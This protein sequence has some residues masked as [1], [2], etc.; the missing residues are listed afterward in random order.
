MTYTLGYG[1]LDEMRRTL[2]V[3]DGEGAGEPFVASDEQAQFVIDFYRVDGEGRR[4]VRRGQ[5]T[6]PK[7]MG[8]SPLAA[9]IA[10]MEAKGPTVFDHFD[11]RV[12]GGAVG[13]VPASPWVQIAGV[14]QDAA[15]NTWA[16]LLG[17]VDPENGSP[18]TEIFPDVDVGLTRI[19]V[20]NGRLEPVTAS[21][22]T[23]RGQRVT[24]AVFD[25]SSLW[26]RSNG[27]LR[28]AE[29]IRDNLAKMGGASL[30]TTNAFVPGEDS[31]AERT[32]AARKSPGV[33][34]DWR[35]SDVEVESLRH[36]RRLRRKLEELYG[37]ASWVDLDRLVE[38]AQ[39]PDVDPHNYRR[40]FL[41][42][43]IAEADAWVSE[44][45]WS[46]IEKPDVSIPDGALVAAGFDGARFDDSTALI[47]VG[48][49]VPAVEVAGLWERPETADAWEVPYDSVDEAVD[50]LHE[51]FQVSRLYAD[52]PHWQDRIDAWAAKYPSVM[53]WETYRGRQMAAAVDRT[54]T[55]IRSGEL[56]H[57]G[58]ERLTR[59][60]LNTRY[61][62]N[63]YGKRLRKKF[64]KSP[65]KIDAAVA[66]CL[67]V[68]A[69]ADAIT[70]GALAKKRY[71]VAGF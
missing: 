42:E 25:E 46:A 10:A 1:V 6:W 27:G 70:S 12:L 20:Q 24:F 57:R 59:H 15:V 19:Y 52:P 56:S 45:E 64:P 8:K 5:L 49:E 67:A 71:A 66:M 37:R 51:R 63:R 30:E 29:T 4:I 11:D 65:D 21:A 22:G 2:V 23:R 61:D 32:W 28:L 55:A 38:E 26:V 35:S 41:N 62:R 47:V 54:E 18:F 44:P 13:R 68:E 39:D 34:V 43:I 69:R 48:L 53:F 17:M 58:D 7:G 31:V 50:I 40:M 9:A 14:S 3:P 36:T 33:L 16:A 60:V